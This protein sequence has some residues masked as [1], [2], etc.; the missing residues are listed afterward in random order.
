M[1]VCKLVQTST[2]LV[3]YLM[4]PHDFILL[5][6]RTTQNSL[7]LAWYF[8]NPVEDVVCLNPSD[9]EVC[10]QRID[11]LK[12]H[13]YYLAGFISYEA[14][15]FLQTP[16]SI[17]DSHIDP[18]FPLLHFKAFKLAQRLSSVEVAGLFNQSDVSDVQI[19]NLFL[20]CSEADYIAKFNTIKE[21]MR[22]GHTYQ[23]NLTAKYQFDFEGC[24]IQLYQQ[25][26]QRQ[27][28][29]YSSLLYFD[30]YQILSLSP[31]LFF[32]KTGGVIQV[33][34]MKGTMPR[35]ENVSQDLE[36]KTFLTTDPK[37]IAENT[38]I[39]DLL[40]NDLSSLSYPGTVDVVSLLKVSSYETLHQM[41]S[42]IHGQ[43][44]PDLAF[45]III[46]QLFPCGS[47]TGV[48]KRRTMEIINEIEQSPRNIYT[49][50]IG[51]IMPN[52]DMCFNV[53][54]RTLLLRQGRGEL[55]VG[56]GIVYDSK[57]QDEFEELKLK[58]RFFTQM[59]GVSSVAQGSNDEKQ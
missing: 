48:P 51:Y 10:L 50:A 11:E 3:A 52:N 44:N 39:V 57:A 35:G 34:P 19:R 38:M 14:S 24:P 7:N 16:F 20:N 13:G 28:V 15:Y 42:T 30:D 49:G 1:L 59:P 27:Q 25:L 33:E 41:T 17:Q 2:D 4:L 21:Y 9:L 12:T 5:E 32:R 18:G 56:G 6:D 31:E 47:I 54:I 46:S 23:V 53:A 36:N 45:K 8:S 37:S 29:P 22:D 43:V 55:G 26:R 40:R 58:A